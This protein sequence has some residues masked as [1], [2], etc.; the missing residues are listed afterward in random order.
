MKADSSRSSQEKSSEFA[1]E[2]RKNGYF[3]LRGALPR[4]PPGLTTRVST[5]SVGTRV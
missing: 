5:G 1:R 2:Q 3:F 4:T